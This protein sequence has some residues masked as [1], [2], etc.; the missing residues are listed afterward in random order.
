MPASKYRS[1]TIG[2][3]LTRVM[4]GY[5]PGLPAGASP[6]R[7][8]AASTPYFVSSSAS[9]AFDQSKPTSSLEYRSG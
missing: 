3:V 5:I 7:Y 1:S 8:I 6:G 2:Q 9:V 4:S